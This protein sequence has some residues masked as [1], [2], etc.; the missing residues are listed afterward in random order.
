MLIVLD[1]YQSR[2]LRRSLDNCPVNIFCYNRECLAEKPR[3]AISFKLDYDKSFM[4]IMIYIIL[5]GKLREKWGIFG[6]FASTIS[7]FF[8]SPRM[9][10]DLLVIFC[11]FDSESRLMRRRLILN[12]F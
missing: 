12:L 3:F 4:K 11:I 5:P 1:F 6:S 8:N 9:K 2:T 10:E 7:S